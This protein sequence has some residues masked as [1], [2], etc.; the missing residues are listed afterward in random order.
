MKIKIQIKHLLTGSVLFEFEKENN[1]TR[2]TVLEAVKRH[3][4]LRYADLSDAD[5]RYADLSDAD[6]RYANLSDADLRYANLSDADLSDANLSDA[7]LRGANLRYANL[8]YANLRYANLRYANLRHANLR[9]ADLSD[10]NLS[11]ANLRYA[12]LRG[13]NLRGADLSD[14][15]LSDADL[16]VIKNDMFLVLLN[17]INEIP[18]LKNSIN[19]GKI[20]GSTYEGECACLCGTLE[21]SDKDTSKRIYDLRDPGRP[22]E[23]LFLGINKGDTPETNEFS[24]LA[25]GWVEEFEFLIN[26]QIKK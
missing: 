3:A 2:D 20:N 6:L 4:N 24:K 26:S 8:R 19:E 22:I 1:T 23:R 21:K 25:L 14:A 17:A 9:Y 5:L 10:A 18:N 16:S 11:D 13:A 7:D 12:D 15:N